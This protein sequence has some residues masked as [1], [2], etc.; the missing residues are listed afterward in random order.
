MTPGPSPPHSTQTTAHAHTRDN[1]QT[2]TANVSPY[3]A[4]SSIAR[5]QVF[6]K[7]PRPTLPSSQLQPHAPERERDMS[8]HNRHTIASR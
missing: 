4:P 3:Y 8:F 7:E 2:T 5:C 1:L 6:A